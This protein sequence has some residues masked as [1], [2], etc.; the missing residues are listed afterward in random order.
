MLYT[1][2][3]TPA[4]TIATSPHNCGPDT[5][6][7]LPM[8]QI[9]YIFKDEALVKYCS[10]LITALATLPI[11]TPNIRSERL[12]FNLLESDMINVIKPNAPAIAAPATPKV[13]KNGWLISTPINEPPITKMATPRPEA[14]L[15]PKIYGSAN[16]FL[17]RVCICKPH[18][19][20][21]IPAS[22]A[23]IA[24]GTLKSRIMSLIYPDA[25]STA[26]ST[27]AAS[28]ELKNTSKICLKG[29][30]TE[31]ETMSAQKHRIRSKAI[32]I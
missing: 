16:G 25:A 4:T 7:K 13:W 9:T 26:A 1:D 12:F 11:I 29:I 5:P 6:A 18:K 2:S 32:G 31:P 23:V 20:K 21:P 10:R 30:S 8:V 15:T 3:T 24:L 28:P 17:K 19:D 14:A 27:P 22:K